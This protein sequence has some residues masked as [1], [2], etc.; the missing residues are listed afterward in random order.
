[1]HT[2]IDKEIQLV[3]M[4]RSYNVSVENVKVI[5]AGKKR[6]LAYCHALRAI[7][8]FNISG[9]INMEVISYGKEA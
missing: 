2:Y 6:I 8:T 1:M 5:M 9:I 3:Y 4:D 7:R